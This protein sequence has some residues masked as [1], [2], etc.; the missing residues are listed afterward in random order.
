MLIVL[1]NSHKSCASYR[2]NR[3]QLQY[4]EIMAP[5]LARIL[6]SGDGTEDLVATI[7]H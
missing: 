7:I 6:L 1:D 2:V 4:A 3:D 5:K